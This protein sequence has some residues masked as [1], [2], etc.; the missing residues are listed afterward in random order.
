VSFPPKNVQSQANDRVTKI[1]ESPYID[2]YGRH[3]IARAV[4]D[5]S[6]KVNNII[7]DAIV[8]CMA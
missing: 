1:G 6:I 7:I 8:I 3:L 4:L 5:E 2:Q